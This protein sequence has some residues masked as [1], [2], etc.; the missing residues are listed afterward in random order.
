MEIFPRITAE[1]DKCGGKPCIRGHRLTVEHL[2][3]L[4]AEGKARKDL[5]SEWDFLEVEDIQA[6]LL[7]ASHLAGERSVAV[8][9]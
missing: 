6:A 7:F 9:S 2:L 3:S 4:L 8:A 5:L 1:P